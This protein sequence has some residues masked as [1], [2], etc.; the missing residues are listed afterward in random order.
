M[1]TSDDDRVVEAGSE[2]LEHE[3]DVGIRAWGR[4]LEEAYE[5]TAWAVADLLGVRGEGPA[6]TGRSVSPA[7]SA[8]RAERSPA[9][10]ART[11]SP[12]TYTA[13]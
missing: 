2:F 1:V 9:S 4:T 10:C 7:A 11:R 12:A 6:R 13:A 8:T 3:A 5:K